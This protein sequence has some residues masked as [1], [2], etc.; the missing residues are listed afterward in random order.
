[1]SN[2]KAVTPKRVDKKTIEYWS[3]QEQLDRI[4]KWA[5]NGLSMKDIANNIGIV[6]STLYEWSKKSQ[7]ISDALHTGREVKLEKV[8]NALFM[9]ATGYDK[10]E[11]HY[12]F[13]EEGNKIPV[14]SRM[15]HYPGEAS[16]IKYYANNVDP[17]NWQDRVTYEDTSAHDKLDKLLNKMEEEAK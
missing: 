10:E 7:H 14:K 12:K 17:E 2:K 5:G 16:L 6:R 1:M 8:V 13:D 11:I 4:E 15:V 3:K 9:R